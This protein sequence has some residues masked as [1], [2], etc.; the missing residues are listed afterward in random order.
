MALIYLETPVK[1]EVEKVMLS[2]H[3][4]RRCQQKLSFLLINECQHRGVI[5]LVVSPPERW[6]DLDLLAGWWRHQI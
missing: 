5:G 3:T 2:K 6:M 1:T 4:T